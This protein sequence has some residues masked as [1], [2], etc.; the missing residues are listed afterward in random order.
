MT[1]IAFYLNEE[2]LCEEQKII[3]FQRKMAH[4]LETLGSIYKKLGILSETMVLETVENF[5]VCHPK[6][7]GIYTKKVATEKQRF[8]AGKET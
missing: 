7:G 5:L 6:I 4:N 3:H 2:I 1:L 8:A